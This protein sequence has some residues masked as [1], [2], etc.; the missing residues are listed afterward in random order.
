MKVLDR[1]LLPFAFVYGSVMRFRNWLYDRDI[2]KSVSFD[3]C[4]IS[5]GN[6][7][8]GGAGKTP[9]TEYL[10]R[11]FRNDYKVATLSRGYGRKTRGFRLAGDE[12]S[13]R[14]IGDEPYQYFLKFPDIRVAVG[15]ER[16][17]AVPFILAEAPE[18]EVIL[19]DDA[20]Q[21]RAVTPDFQV[22]VSDYARLFTRDHLLPAGRLRE[23][24]TGAARADVIV[25][26]K[27]PSDLTQ[28]ESERITREVQAYASDIPVYF[29]TID[30]KEPVNA[31]GIPSE[32]NKRLLVTGIARPEPLVASLSAQY[33]LTGHMVYPDHHNFTRRDI[34]HIQ[35]QAH[36][37]NAAVITT[38][39]DM[40]RL[41]EPGLRELLEDVPVFYVPI[42]VRFL[43][44][45]GKFRTQ[46]L[47]AA[48][49]AG[50]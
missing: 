2:R 23:P 6:L 14:T 10:I 29:T 21:H 26:S 34:M 13:A 17:V 1:L 44:E 11:L 16:A 43:F 48:E 8:A 25:V 15:E 12:D 49:A 40:M 18:T 38:E 9:M 7:S 4:L 22:L 3:R 39:K 45:E 50:S 32:N 5:V 31:T 35:E 33:E 27:C 37:D 19:L 41:M 46:L 28:S 42:Q 20:F 24:R 36:S 30:Y 47:K